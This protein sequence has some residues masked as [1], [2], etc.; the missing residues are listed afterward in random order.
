MKTQ[1]QVMDEANARLYN[2]CQPGTY[3]EQQ[4]RRLYADCQYCQDHKN[5][6]MMPPH[7]A[8]DHCESG[9]RNHCTCDI[10]Y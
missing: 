5:D 2:S 10:C 6:S 4:R 7:K 3:E 1:R 8:S 9:K